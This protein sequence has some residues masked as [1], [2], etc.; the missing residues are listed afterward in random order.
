[1]EKNDKRVNEESWLQLKALH[2]KAYQENLTLISQH[3][4][5]PMLIYHQSTAEEIESLTEVF[6]SALQSIQCLLTYK[7]ELI[8]NNKSLKRDLSIQDSNHDYSKD[9]QI[10]SLSSRLTKTVDLLNSVTKDKKF[11]ETFFEESE[12]MKNFAQGHN[13]AL[14]EKIRAL[15]K[16]NGNLSK[17]QLISFLNSVQ[18]KQEQVEKRIEKYETYIQSKQKIN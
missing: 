2:D 3:Q 6:S 14:A 1:M 18:C 7:S 10:L 9:Q 11:L 12:S 13:E 4:Q 8:E 16:P 17:T 5:D 15:A